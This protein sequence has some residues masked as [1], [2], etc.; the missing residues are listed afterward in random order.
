[1]CAECHN[2]KFDPYTQADFYSVA[3]FFADIQE[4]AVGGRG[5]GTPIPQKPERGGRAEA[6]RAAG[7][8]RAGEA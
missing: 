2:H 3:A 7:R 4:P 5:P 8:D 1:M 6:Q